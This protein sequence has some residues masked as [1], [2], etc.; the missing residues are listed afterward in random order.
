[1]S[2]EDVRRP[3]RAST[4]R[5]CLPW[6]MFSVVTWKDHS[7]LMRAGKEYTPWRGKFCS[8]SSPNYTND[9]LHPVYL[10]VRLGS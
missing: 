1:M 9:I 5:W 2:W 8:N 4:E 10:A 6:V 7:Y 3:S